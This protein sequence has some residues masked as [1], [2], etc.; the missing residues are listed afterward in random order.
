MTEPILMASWLGHK[1]VPISKQEALV[2]GDSLLLF[3][4]PFQIAG[5]ANFPAKQ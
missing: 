3:R 5:S 2:F 4:F 1:P